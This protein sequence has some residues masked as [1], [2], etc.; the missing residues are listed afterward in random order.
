MKVKELRELLYKFNEDS[1]VKV[2][3][4][5]DTVEEAHD[6]DYVVCLTTY[7][8]GGTEEG[9]VIKVAE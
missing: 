6:I 7:C 1:E 9:I 4:E 2:C 8:E 3:R 5:Y